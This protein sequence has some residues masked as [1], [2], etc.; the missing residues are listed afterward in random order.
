[1][2][3]RGDAV[4]DAELLQSTFADSTRR[5]DE[6]TGRLFR[7]SLSSAPTNQPHVHLIVAD[8]AQ[9][10]RV[11]FISS[12]RRCGRDRPIWVPGCRRWARVR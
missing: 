4:E 6:I 3:L 8:D 11:V 12:V 1:V 5:G 2:L 7:L 9:P 10:P